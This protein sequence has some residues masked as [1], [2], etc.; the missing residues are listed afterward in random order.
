MSN[1][2]SVFQ[3]ISVINAR[4]DRFRAEEM[5]LRFLNTHPDF[6]RQYEA[7][8]PEM[9]TRLIETIINGRMMNPIWTISNDEDDTEEVLDGMHRITTIL[10][11]IKCDFKLMSKHFIELS[12]SEYDN[13]LY[14]DLPKPIKTK[15]KNYELS[16]NQLDGSFRT[17][18]NKRQ[19]MY[20]L[21]NKSSVPLNDF[22][23]N[24]V[25]LYKFY[26][27]V[28]KYKEQLKE[29][30]FRKQDKRGI[31]ETE[32]I[33]MFALS[34]TLPKS[35]GSIRTL[36]EYFYKQNMGSTEQSV[37]DYLS[38]NK[39]HIEETVEFTFKVI[40]TLYDNHIFVKDSKQIYNS[41]FT[42][43]KFIIARLVLIFDN[44][45]ASFNKD[46]INILSVINNEILNKEIDTIVTELKC[47]Q[48][49]A[50]FQR[51]LINKLD[52]IIRECCNGTQARA[53]PKKMIDDKLIEQDGKCASCLQTKEYW[54]G[55]HIIE[56]SKGGATNFD[57]LQVLCRH[58][59]MEKSGQSI[60]RK[61]EEEH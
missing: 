6:Q 54:E 34:H 17:D 8:T 16:F 28:T 10:N 29:L 38:K 20:C 15:I 14:E 31:I 9:K 23:Y 32:I 46:I 48:R 2:K 21:L 49:N 42:I 19:S 11:F 5:E 27:L 50:H 43:Y 36:T 25:L 37:N 44:K 18:A 57:N 24:K 47:T 1:T 7:W 56:W 58:C 22:E 40:K 55:D 53:F 60:K 3:Q 13:C 33:E 39:K 61:N 35:W 59:H 30:F 4:T 45:I 52:Y 51:S 12:N 26:N 41:Y